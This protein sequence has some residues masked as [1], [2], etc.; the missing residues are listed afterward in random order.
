MWVR[1]ALFYALVAVG[2]V[3]CD[4]DDEP[5]DKRMKGLTLCTELDPSVCIGGP[6]NWPPDDELRVAYAWKKACEQNVWTA[7]TSLGVLYE[8]G[9]VVHK[10]PARSISFYTN[11]CNGGDGEA[12]FRMSRLYESGV[13][14]N[15]TMPSTA[16]ELRAKGCAKGYV[17]ACAK[18]PGATVVRL[19]AFEST[20][21]A[22]YRHVGFA[23]DVDTALRQAIGA[24]SL[25]AKECHV[26]NGR[27]C[28]DLGW[29]YQRGQGGLAKD[30]ARGVPFYRRACDLGHARG[31]DNLGWVYQ[32]G[33]GV[34]RD[35]KRALEAYVKACDGNDANACNNLGWLHRNGIGTPKDEVIAAPLF[36]K[37]CE[38]SNKFGCANLAWLYVQ[39][40]GVA[41]DSTKAETLYRRSCSLGYREA[42]T[43][44][45]RMK[46]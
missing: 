38:A 21:D 26:G 44:A 20:P 18:D 45:S 8:E 40:L 29:N 19:G 42:C 27:A 12:C 17:R 16:K 9:R 23:L 31:C 39:G 22:G 10:A 43:T 24:G 34:A 32:K 6:T 5:V 11:A 14:G 13:V 25:L 35:D 33:I 1:I 7:C 28:N 2:L 41:K 30:E 3:G 36:E 46:R 15:I 37:A 4:D